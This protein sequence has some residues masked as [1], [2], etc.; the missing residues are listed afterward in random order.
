M[1]ND[2]ARHGRTQDAMPSLQG[3]KNVMM[4]D[5]KGMVHDQ[6]ID[7]FLQSQ[8]REDDRSFQ[9]RKRSMDGPLSRRWSRRMDFG[10]AYRAPSHFTWR[11]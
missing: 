11:Y 6:Q 8:S 5:S 7:T 3:M 4:D 9:S 1:T 2:T 10:E